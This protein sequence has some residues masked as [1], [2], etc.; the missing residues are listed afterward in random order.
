MEVLF[1]AYF[2]ECRDIIN[3]QTLIDVVVGAGMDR[4]LAEALLDG[5]EGMEAIKD[6]EQLSRR[7]R[8]DGVPFFIINNEITLSGAQQPEVFLEA[9]RMADVSE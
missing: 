8:V 4:K 1:R 2:T 6:A 9:F 7:H 5:D 3:R